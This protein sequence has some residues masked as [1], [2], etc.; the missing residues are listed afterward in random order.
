MSGRG[1]FWRQFLKNPQAVASVAPSGL[2]LSLAM[3]CA[4]PNTAQR[5]VE[6]GA[7]TGPITQALLDTAP[8]GRHIMAV[9]V[10]PELAAHVQRR[11]PGVN[12]HAADARTLPQLC[13]DRGW[14]HADAVVSS[15]GFRALPNDIGDALVRA[16]D[17]ALAPNG[18]MIQFTYGLR[19]PLPKAT[20]DALGWV[21]RERRWVVA[22]LPPAFVHVYQKPS[23][24]SG[25]KP[26][27]P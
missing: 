13:R 12:V 22:N 4:V 6:L 24:R 20:V 15:L 27:A 14:P 26:C 10:N 7:G 5:V 3:A 21:H 25:Q 1:A 16:V 17:Q 23:Q 8:T 11:C 9:E 2:A 19:R 18:V